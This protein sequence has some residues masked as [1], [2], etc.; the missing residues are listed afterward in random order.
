MTKHELTSIQNRA[1]F[2]SLRQVREQTGYTQRHVYKLTYEGYFGLMR[3][4]GRYLF[5]SADAVQAYLDRVS[6][7]NRHGHAARP[8]KVAA[9]ICRECGFRLGKSSTPDEGD[10]CGF[11]V[12]E[13]DE[14]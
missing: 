6:G 8:V 13:R 1:G 10:L 3:K 9:S 11:C 14:N 5:V 7:K 4:R 12:E 2:L